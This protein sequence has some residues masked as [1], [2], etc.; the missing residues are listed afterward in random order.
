MYWEERNEIGGE[1]TKGKEKETYRE[2][3]RERGGTGK[4]SPKI[5]YNDL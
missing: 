4:K 5:L 3:E 2:R 1:K